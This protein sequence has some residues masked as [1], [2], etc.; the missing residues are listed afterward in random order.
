MQWHAINP[1]ASKERGKKAKGKEKKERK[2]KKEKNEQQKRE[3]HLRK[4]NTPRNNTPY[5]IKDRSGEEEKKTPSLRQDAQ[6]TR[7]CPPGG[8]AT[9]DTKKNPVRRAASHVESS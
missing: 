1:D 3:T 8:D 5:E 9:G 4:T 6:T 2:K 7:S